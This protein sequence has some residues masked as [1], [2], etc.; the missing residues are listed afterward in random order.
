MKSIA[1]FLGIGLCA[2]SA[3][4]WA[5]EADHVAIA[6]LMG[7]TMFASRHCGTL[8]IN[9]EK[10]ATFLKGFGA[11]D[12]SDP[13]LIDSSAAVK[14]AAALERSGDPARTCDA[15]WRRFGANGTVGARLFRRK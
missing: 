13:D 11:I 4:A 15:L 5:A 10:Y 9:A 1:A 8:E 7:T 14:V 12:A 2:A 6:G 3:P